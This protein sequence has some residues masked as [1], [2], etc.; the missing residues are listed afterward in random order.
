MV[1]AHQDA[2]IQFLL[3]AKQQ[4][5]AAQGDDATVIPCLPG[6]HQLEYRAGSYLYRDIYFGTAYFVG[7]ETLYDRHQPVWAMSYAGGVISSNTSPEDVATIYTFLRSALLLVAHDRPYRGPQAYNHDAY[8]YNDESWG[9]VDRF[10]G[11]EIITH[12]GIC[13]YE[14]YYN[15]GFLL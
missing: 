11:H 3:D 13:V 14:L 10:H 6:S 12:A 4:T 15:G 7:Q 5:Y 1:L 2:F 9:S 8:V